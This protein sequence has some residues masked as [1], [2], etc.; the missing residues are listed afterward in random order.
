MSVLNWRMPSPCLARATRR[1]GGSPPAHRGASRDDSQ[2]TLC[3][4]SSLA[5]LT[6]SPHT[7]PSVKPPSDSVAVA[8]LLLALVLAIWVLPPFTLHPSLHTAATIAFE[9]GLAREA[10][11]KITSHRHADELAIR[12]ILTSYA[13]SAS[14]RLP[15]PPSSP[16]RPCVPTRSL[17]LDG[18]NYRLRLCSWRRLSPSCVATLIESKIYRHL[19]R[20]RR[21]SPSHAS[22]C[23]RC[24][25]GAARVAFRRSDGDESLR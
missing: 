1:R 24:V 6:T 17:A 19:S 10:A 22:A 8:C 2:K 16:P 5:Q 13:P 20:A 23:V 4:S 11:I 14:P 25:S 12:R 15:V 21:G 9:C 3:L 18:D 7:P